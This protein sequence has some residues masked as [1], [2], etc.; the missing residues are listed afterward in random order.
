LHVWKCGCGSSTTGCAQPSPLTNGYADFSKG[1]SGQ[2]RGRFIFRPRKR[3][4]HRCSRKSVCEKRWEFARFT[5]W[6]RS[7]VM[8]RSVKPRT[9]TR[10]TRASLATVR[11]QWSR[12]PAHAGADGGAT[13]TALPLALEI[14]PAAQSG[15]EDWGR[16]DQLFRHR[17]GRSCSRAGRNI[18]E[19][20]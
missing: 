8:G 6:P 20:C 15:G 11:R 12:C 3:L 4:S 9:Q 13:P 1:P 10:A 5:T 16:P 17:L 14:G 18:S 7:T 19:A 2:A